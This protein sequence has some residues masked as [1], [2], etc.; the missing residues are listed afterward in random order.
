M[1]FLL[2]TGIF[3]CHI[4]L[5]EGNLLVFGR[6]LITYKGPWG[7]HAPSVSWFVQASDGQIKKLGHKK[8]WSARELPRLISKFEAIFEAEHFHFST[9]HFVMYQIWGNV[10]PLETNIYIPWKIAGWKINDEIS[11]LKGALFHREKSFFFWGGSNLTE[12]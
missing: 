2:K 1:C 8:R 7:F 10:P 3:H 4:T 12:T 6:F 9:H 5:L 11:F